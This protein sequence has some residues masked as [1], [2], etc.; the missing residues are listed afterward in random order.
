ML[1]QF[2]SIQKKMDSRWY[3]SAG[4]YRNVWITKTNLGHIAHWGIYLTTP[5][6]S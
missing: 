3:P 1:L 6:I 2:G 5:A 4:I